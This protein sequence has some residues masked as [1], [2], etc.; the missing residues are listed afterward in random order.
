[1]QIILMEK[2]R[3]PRQPRGSAQGEGRLCTQLPDSKGQ[4][5]RATPAALKEFEAKRAELESAAADR[6]AAAQA[7]AEKLGWRGRDDCAQGRRRWSSVWIGD[8]L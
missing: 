8:Q 3:Q 2:G 4:A 1:M 6:V 5:K 7:Y